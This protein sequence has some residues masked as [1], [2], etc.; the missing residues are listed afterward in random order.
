M[1]RNVVAP[2][3]GATPTRKRIR[4][5]AAP[6]D[7]DGANVWADVAEGEAGINV[8]LLHVYPELNPAPGWWVECDGKEYE[9]VAV[10]PP[11]GGPLSMLVKPKEG[12]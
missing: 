7:P 6:H 12:A 3:Q 2:G 4:L 5:A 1:G 8:V 11:A 9:V 10:A